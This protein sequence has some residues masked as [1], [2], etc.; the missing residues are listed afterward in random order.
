MPL[1]LIRK[2]FSS[3]AKVIGKDAILKAIGGDIEVVRLAG[4]FLTEDKVIANTSWSKLNLNFQ[5]KHQAKPMQQISSSGSSKRSDRY[6]RKKLKKRKSTTST[7]MSIS[8]IAEAAIATKEVIGK[9]AS[10][11]L[12]KKAGYWSVQLVRWFIG[13]RQRSGDTGRSD[14]PR[15]FSIQDR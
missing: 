4:R 8:L 6:P 10:W 7:K 3:C 11:K 13:R 15:R 2:A 14:E 9:D 1:S 12:S 5:A